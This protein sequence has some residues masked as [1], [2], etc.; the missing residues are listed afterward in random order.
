MF[1]G[2]QALTEA[3]F[4]QGTG[5]IWLSNVTCLGSERVLINCTSEFAEGTSCTHSQDA[6]VR[7]LSG[8]CVHHNVSPHAKN[9]SSKGCIEGE[10][11]LLEGR[12]PLEGRVEI[13]KN[14]IWGTVCNTSWTSTDARIVCR[15]LGFS[16]AGKILGTQ[17][18]CD[19][20]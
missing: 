16:V 15:Q 13:C 20:S 3:N 14:N 9:G 8:S 1:A 5:R 6:G 2:S 18:G 4:G 11:R 7:C 12:I 17:N 10:V 19:T